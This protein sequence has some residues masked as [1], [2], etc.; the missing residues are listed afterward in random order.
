MAKS[1]IFIFGIIMII[2]STASV[3]IVDQNLL[4]VFNYTNAQLNTLCNNNSFATASN[5]SLDSN[6]FEIPSNS[7]SLLPPEIFF[8]TE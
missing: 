2:V 6:S 4:H 5:A 3:T 1:S 7:T 8:N